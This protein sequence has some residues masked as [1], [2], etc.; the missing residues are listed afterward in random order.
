V[1]DE[2]EQA[3]QT[4]AD[5]TEDEQKEVLNQITKFENCI[6]NHFRSTQMLSTT[7]LTPYQT[8]AKGLLSTRL[9]FKK[10]L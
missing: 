6:N 4:S 10:V 8:A 3:Q 7:L 1:I 5:V 9:I 2:P